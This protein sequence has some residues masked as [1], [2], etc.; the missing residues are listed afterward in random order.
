[1][2]MCGALCLPRLASCHSCSLFR[3][4]SSRPF[5]HLVACFPPPAYR[6]MYTILLFP[7]FAS[8]FPFLGLILFLFFFFFFCFSTSMICAQHRQANFA[9]AVRDHQRFPRQRRPRFLHR[10]KQDLLVLVLGGYLCHVHAQ[11]P[12]VR[13]DAAVFQPLHELLGQSAGYG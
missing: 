9:L 6:L 10:T 3:G 13:K 12:K 4:V 11:V 2:G 8:A 5:S 1:M 7:F